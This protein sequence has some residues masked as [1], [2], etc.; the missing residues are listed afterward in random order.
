MSREELPM[1]G[2]VHITGD[3]DSGKTTLAYSVGVPPDE[4][5]F[6][7]NDLK[8]EELHRQLHFGSYFNLVRMF[9]QNNGSKP[10]DFYVM[11]KRLLDDM[12]DDKFSLLVFDNFSQLEDG[13][14]SW[15]EDHIQSVS[16]L[17]IGQAK[18]ASPLTWTAKRIHYASILDL[19]L[20]KAPLVILTTHLRDR[21]VGM[22]KTEMK[23]ARCQQPLVE[24]SSLRIWLKHNSDSPAPIGLILK[25]TS[26]S[27]YNPETRLIEIHS[28]L[29]RRM[30]P[31]TWERIKWYMENP[32]GNRR[33]TKEETPTEYEL[34]ILDG[35]L[36]KDQKLMLELS[37]KAGNQ[38]PEEVE[39]GT[40]MESSSVSD[41]E[42]LK[43]R[44]TG[45]KAP[46]IARQL[47]ISVPKVLE[48]LSNANS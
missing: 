4:I 18:N 29:P 11:V 44:A 16:N 41:D 39:G 13:I 40:V 37:M 1:T 6:I 28:V 2:I 46:A 38:E 43:L 48:V 8:G 7:D 24:K 35:T 30:S 31:C 34:S 25:R 15:T 17:T 27:V 33:P 22:R 20:S 5:A 47:N 36:T 21:W 23:E 9:R 3:V 26:S 14:N 12:P 45:L 32:I 19:M 42:I 10:V